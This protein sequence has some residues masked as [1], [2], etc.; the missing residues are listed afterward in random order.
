MKILKRSLLLLLGIFLILTALVFSFPNQYGVSRSINIKATPEKIYALIAAPKE[1]KKWSVWNQRDPK[2]EMKYSGPE[3]GA[4]AMWDWK[5]AS[6]GNGGMKFFAVAPNQAIT[7]ELHF[8]G[9][10]KPSTGAFTL[11]NNNGLTQVTWSMT[12]TSE[13]NL[14]MKY[15]APFMDKMVGPDF[16]AG[17]KNLKEVAEKE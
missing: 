16:E 10:G 4:G 6:E 8:E 12:G 17:L 2:M 13:G 5:S 3:S 14:M 9:M 7:Y 11:E 1:W 15:F